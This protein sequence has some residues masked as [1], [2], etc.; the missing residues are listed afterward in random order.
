MST[1]LVP[2][3]LPSTL[4][5]MGLRLGRITENEVWALCPAHERRAG[6]PDTTAKNFSVNRNTGDAFC[7]SCRY[8]ANLVG[9]VY[10]T[11]GLDMWEALAWLREHGA[12]LTEHVRRIN[13]VLSEP[14]RARRS[15]ESAKYDLVTLDDPDLE[16][17]LMEPPPDEA[18]E[19]RN[20][21]RL[22]VDRF[23]VRWK[24][25]SWILPF[26]EGGRVYGWQVKQGSFVRNHPKDKVKKSRFLFGAHL[27][28]SGQRLYVVES[29]LDAVR[30]HTAGYPGGVATFGSAVS[31]AQIRLLSTITDDVV[32]VMD[33][34]ESGWS[35]TSWCLR[36]LRPRLRRL[37]VA[38]YAE[39]SGAKDP[40]DLTDAGID[41]LLE[42][43]ESAIMW[44]RAVA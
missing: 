6:K 37:H 43:T 18:L 33:N 41:S 16:F 22:S 19:K 23:R 40:G 5:D 4:Q 21:S 14:E 1:V 44:K 2:H 9:L 30:L 32:L 39:V 36:E 26:I 38:T 15:E 29:P 20:L 24:D 28:K 13:E 42:H 35:S 8:S 10:E 7:F 34:D 12:S 27:V 25:D 31:R 11:M 17:V 3:D